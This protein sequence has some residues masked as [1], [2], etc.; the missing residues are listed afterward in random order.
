M[1]F[2]LSGTIGATGEAVQHCA[3]SYWGVSGGTARRHHGNF[4]KSLPKVMIPSNWQ[5]RAETVV[6][7]VAERRVPTSALMRSKPGEA[8][9]GTV[10]Q[11]QLAH[12]GPRA[13]LLLNASYT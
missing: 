13:A 5:G 1:A 3:S 9:G 12:P 11:S 2:H 6:D 10:P 8:A 7:D 4:A